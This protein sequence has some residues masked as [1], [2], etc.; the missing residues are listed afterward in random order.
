MPLGA[1]DA[2]Y[3]SGADA[4]WFVKYDG[5]N[6]Y[7]DAFVVKLR[8]WGVVSRVYLPLVLNDR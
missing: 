7:Y 6:F 5:T 2:V 3:F 8:T 1:Q 4:P